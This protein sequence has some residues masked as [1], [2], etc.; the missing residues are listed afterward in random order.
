MTTDIPNDTLPGITKSLPEAVSV[1]SRT[2][3]CSSLQSVINSCYSSSSLV[4]MY[5]E[6]HASVPADTLF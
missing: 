6:V 5:V 3:S 1:L 4:Y 2:D